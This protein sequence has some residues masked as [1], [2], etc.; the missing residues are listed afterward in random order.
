M[1][2]NSLYLFLSLVGI[3]IS[4]TQPNPITELHEKLVFERNKSIASKIEGYLKTK[5]HYFVVVGAAHSVGKDGIIEI[6]KKRDISL[7]NFE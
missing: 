5:E 1:R 7:N 2:K 4:I 3:Q 6:L